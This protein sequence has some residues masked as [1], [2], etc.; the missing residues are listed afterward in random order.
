MKTF[1]KFLILLQIPFLISCEREISNKPLSLLKK[2]LC[3]NYLSDPNPYLVFD[4]RYNSKQLADTIIQNNYI[5]EVLHYNPDNTI[6]YKNSFE[7]YGDSLGWLLKDSTS[8]HYLNGQ[9]FLEETFGPAPY[10][11]RIIFKY[12]FENSR[13]VRKYYYYNQNFGNCTIYEYSNN[14]IEKE[15]LCSDSLGL[16]VKSYVLNSYRDGRLCR[17]DAFLSNGIQIQQINYTYDTGGALVLEVSEQ[18]YFEIQKS[19]GYVYKY[20][21]Y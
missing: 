18:L 4:Y 16:E 3:Y 9:L 11:D 19:L 6:R 20:E 2:K 12:I 8:Y 15:T 1:L 7:D 21:Y 5:C 14:H 13:L 10:N 17:S